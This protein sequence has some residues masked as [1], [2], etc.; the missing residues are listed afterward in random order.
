MILSYRKANANCTRFFRFRS[1]FQ[2]LPG[3]ASEVSIESKGRWRGGRTHGQDER[4][5][6]GPLQGACFPT[7]PPSFPR[8]LGSKAKN[9]GKMETLATLPTLE[10]QNSLRKTTAHPPARNEFRPWRREGCKN[11]WFF[12]AGASHSLRATVCKP[13]SST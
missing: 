2:A 3:E 1:I 9:A 5:R 6:T 11:P 4:E 7:L 10:C 8:G 13:P 12:A